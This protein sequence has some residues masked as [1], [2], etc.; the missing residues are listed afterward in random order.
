MDEIK[1][2][3]TDIFSKFLDNPV[4]TNPFGRNRSGDRMYRRAERLIA[5][6][7]LMTN[8]VPTDEPLRIESRRVATSILQKA[9]ACRDEL[10]S[11]TSPALLE[12]QVAVRHLISLTRL[13]VFG[14]F[15]SGQNAEVVVGAADELGSFITT[16][17]RSALSES[18]VFYKE[19]LTDVPD[20][21]K[22]QKDIRDRALVRD[23]GTIKD[24]REVSFI[25]KTDGTSTSV[26]SRGSGIV[27]ILRSGG[28]LNIRD[29]AA[30]LPE[31]GEKTIQRELNTLIQQGVVK[32]TGLKRWSKYSLS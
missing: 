14:G 1:D 32:R 16:A 5:A 29:I 15:I 28:E 22:G 19:E 12:F 11:S 26:S 27:G 24:R 7:F 30:N 10:R 21:F 9:L 20:L 8:H 3:K 17:S 31:Y 23:T 25:S 2:T 6:V 18:F 13:M 4:A